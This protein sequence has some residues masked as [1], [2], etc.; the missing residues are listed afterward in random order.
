MFMTS[1]IFRLHFG[2]CLRLGFHDGLITFGVVERWIDDDTVYYVIQ[3][4]IRDRNLWWS[5]PGLEPYLGR[6]VGINLNQRTCQLEVVAWPDYD[7]RLAVLS[8]PGTEQ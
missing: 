3:S 4:L 2:H 5:H 1:R 6:C 8:D 7:Q